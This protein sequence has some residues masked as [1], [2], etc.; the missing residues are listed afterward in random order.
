MLELPRATL[1]K[2]KEFLRLLVGSTWPRESHPAINSPW[3]TGNFHDTWMCEWLLPQP[4]PTGTS[5]RCY[6]KREQWVKATIYSVSFS[7]DCW[8]AL[9]DGLALFT[10]HKCWM[11]SLGD[12][13][14]RNPEKKTQL[15]AAWWWKLKARFQKP[16]KLMS[17]WQSANN[18][19]GIKSPLFLSPL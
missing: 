13:T 18:L 5:Q 19:S 4:Y 7:C 1:E 6:A 3:G 11:P 15:L 8:W 2:S 16:S 14:S 9:E 17:N 12:R 10:P